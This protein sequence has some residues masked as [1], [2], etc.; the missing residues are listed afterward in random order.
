MDVPCPRITMKIYFGR[1]PSIVFLPNKVNA[2]LARDGK[3]GDR[4]C[5][6]LG[7]VCWA[8]LARGTAGGAFG[9]TLLGKGH[10][11]DQ[12]RFAD[13]KVSGVPGCHRYLEA[14][15]IPSHQD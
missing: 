11:P 13:H 2:T 7:V 3:D 14:Y 12:R 1:H 9:L 8:S 4:G 6:L 5:L 10:R 15:T